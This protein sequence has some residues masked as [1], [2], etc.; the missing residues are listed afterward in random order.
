MGRSRKILSNRSTSPFRTA[1]EPRGGRN[2][3]GRVSGQEWICSKEPRSNKC[4]WQG[5]SPSLDVYSMS[6]LR[7]VSSHERTC[8]QLWGETHALSAFHMVGEGGVEPPGL[9][10]IEPD[11]DRLK[12]APGA[13]FRD[14]SFC[15]HLCVC[16][17]RSTLPNSH[18]DPSS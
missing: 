13:A 8:I 18:E 10:V 14:L 11:A 6:A 9:R 15:V 16:P 5:R 7:F 17:N 12:I 2:A 3:C 1:Q 4:S